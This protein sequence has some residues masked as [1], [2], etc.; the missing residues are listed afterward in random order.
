MIT[1]IGDIEVAARIEGQS[2]GEIELS[3]CGRACISGESWSTAS[4]GNKGACG[5]I[6]L[7]DA[8]VVAISDVEIIGGV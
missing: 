8:V 3:R 4:Y 5:E 1:G 2:R 7:T 6:K